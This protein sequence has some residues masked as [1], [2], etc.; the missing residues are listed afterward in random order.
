MVSAFSTKRPEV[1]A[2]EPDDL[3]H[4]HCFLRRSQRDWL[5][6]QAGER[7]I[8][9]VVRF[10]FDL[11]MEN[12]K[13]LD[14][15][16]AQQ[17]AA[18]RARALEEAVTRLEFALKLAP[19]QERIAAEVAGLPQAERRCIELHLGL[20]GEGRKLTFR[21]IGAELGISG[22]RAHQLYKQGWQMLAKRRRRSAPR[23]GAASAN[24]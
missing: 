2:A 3:V 17:T 19:E 10:L 6:G 15:A 23:R 14:A 7:G 22:Q 4:F 18:A 11:V 13:L 12:P 1:V 16:A 20:A 24:S 9:A 5:A 8:A 21:E